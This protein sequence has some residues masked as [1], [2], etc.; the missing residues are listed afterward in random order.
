MEQESSSIRIAEWLL[1]TATVAGPILAVQA[2]KLVE[3][4]TEAR[5][6]KLWIFYT[7]MATR[8][9]RAAPE[10]VQALNAIDLAF[11]SDKPK[12]KAIREAWG[13]YLDH[14]VL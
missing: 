6:R 13:L 9:A 7:L 5:N 4:L 8:A 1:I 11:R 2:Q 3:R 12:E 10:H 14:L